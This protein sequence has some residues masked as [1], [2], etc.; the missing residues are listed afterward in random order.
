MVNPV[1]MLINFK[2]IRDKRFDIQGVLELMD[3]FKFLSKK[4]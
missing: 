2:Q 1:M 3:Y 4:C